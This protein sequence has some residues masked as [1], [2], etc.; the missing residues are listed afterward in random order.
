MRLHDDHDDHVPPPPPHEAGLPSRDTPASGDDQPPL[1]DRRPREDGRASP[2]PAEP[3][4]PEERHRGRVFATALVAA[5]LASGLPLGI[6][7][8]L[9]SSTADGAGGTLPDGGADVSEPGTEGR[10]ALP[11]GGA[12]GP[13][14]A[15]AE[16]TPITSTVEVAEAVAPSV[17]DVQ[18][19]VSGPGG[20]T[21]VGEG[22]AVVFDADGHLITNDHVVAGAESVRVRLADGS[23]HD[24]EVV[25]TDE[26]SDLAVLRIDSEDL[27]TPAWRDELPRVGEE[28]VAIGSPFGLE[29]T[30]TSGIV[31]ALDRTMPT[32]EVTLTGLIQTDAAINPGNSGGP[33]V[34]ASGR[35]IGINTAIYSRSGAN[36]GVGFAV[37]STTVV[38]VAETLI[39]EGEVVWPHLGVAGGDVDARVAEAYDLP[40]DEGALIADVLDDGPAAAAGIEEEDIVVGF[41]GESITSMAELAA[42]VTQRQ[43]GDV[44]TVEVIRGGD[45]IELEAELAPAP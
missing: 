36:D 3:R 31:S 4:Q 19:T 22:S 41:D 15:D 2:H 30:V 13:D 44:V 10:E 38:R 40:A 1:V 8:F 9:D 26:R 17:A 6:S 39:S 12:D 18:V 25:G 33:L 42:A 35:V 7:E 28:A 43:V 24:A 45:E 37:P 11:D 34:D 29:G 20:S 14:G 21:G 32:G 23:S 27:P 5:V 16:T